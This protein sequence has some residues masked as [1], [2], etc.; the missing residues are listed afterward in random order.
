MQFKAK[1]QYADQPSASA[2]HPRALLASAIKEREQA[3][4]ALAD[5]TNAVARAGEAWSTAI[6]KREALRRQ[7]P[8]PAPDIVESIL[9]GDTLALERPDEKA[10]KIAEAEGEIERWSSMRDAAEQAVEARERALD[11][12]EKIVD[13]QARVVLGSVLD[14]TTM[15][16]DARDAADWIVNQRAGFL[17][18]MSILPDGHD[19]QALADF[20]RRPFL[21]GEYDDGWRKNPSIKPFADALAALQHDADAAIDLAP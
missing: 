21:Q 8:A 4:R 16:K 20:M 19:H 12:A 7:E 14:V 5:A 17:Y 6:D 18:L 15:L 10:R 3:A 11:R 13:S 2:D 9:S 1:G